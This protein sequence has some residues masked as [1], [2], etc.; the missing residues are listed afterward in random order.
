MGAVVVVAKRETGGTTLVLGV[1][2]GSRRVRGTEGAGEGATSLV[3]PRL[4]L[5]GR[6]LGFRLSCSSSVV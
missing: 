6:L 5:R 3:R 2:T 1:G 4:L